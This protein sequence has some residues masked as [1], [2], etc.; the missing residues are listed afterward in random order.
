[1]TFINV[2]PF[3]STSYEIVVKLLELSTCSGERVF[4]FVLDIYSQM[5]R[6][7]GLIGNNEHEVSVNSLL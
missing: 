7:Y 4:F 2:L 3:Y 1:M 5:F 6:F